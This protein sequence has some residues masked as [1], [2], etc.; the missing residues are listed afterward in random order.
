MPEEE[1]ETCWRRL[2]HV[3]YNNIAVFFTDRDGCTYETLK[4]FDN[5]PYERKTMFTHDDYSEFKSAFY[6]DCFS[7]E[8]EVGVSTEYS[9]D[10]LKIRYLDEYDYVALLNK[11]ER[12]GR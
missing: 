8:Q 5:L 7:K 11:N 10:K 3:D 1:A 12:F 9:N 6:Y 2:K 4:R